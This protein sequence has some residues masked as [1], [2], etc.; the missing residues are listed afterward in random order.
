MAADTASE[1]GFGSAEGDLS[2][3]IP[4]NVAIISNTESNKIRDAMIRILSFLACFF[5]RLT[6]GT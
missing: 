6:F 2:V 1:A 3:R 5:I 4:G